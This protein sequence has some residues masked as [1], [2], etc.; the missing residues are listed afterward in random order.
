MSDRLGF[1]LPRR[2]LV[3]LAKLINWGNVGAGICLKES[4]ECFLE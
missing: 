2:K 1:F 3:E 4:V